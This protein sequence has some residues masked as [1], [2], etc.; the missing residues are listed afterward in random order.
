MRLK[1][2]PPQKRPAAA[3]ICPGKTGQNQ[4]DKPAPDAQDGD[5]IRQLSQTFHFSHE[6]LALML[7]W[8]YHRYR[9][10][11]QITGSVG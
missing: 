2:R 10:T 3:W 6:I 11:E 7:Q 4:F 8:V 9:I 5:N 1:F